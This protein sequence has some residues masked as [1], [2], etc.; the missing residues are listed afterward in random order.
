MIVFIS[1]SIKLLRML[2]ER[3][4]ICLVCYLKCTVSRIAVYMDVF[5]QVLQVPHIR[6]LLQFSFIFQQ[7]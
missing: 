2:S 6:D 7:D 5:P 3:H 4:R 1:F